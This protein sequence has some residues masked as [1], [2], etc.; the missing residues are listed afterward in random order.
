MALN[1]KSGT[2]MDAADD[3]LRT[4]ERFQASLSRSTLP[5]HSMAIDFPQ[6]SPLGA[7]ALK[8]T[9]QK[10]SRTLGVMCEPEDMLD[11]MTDVADATAT[12]LQDIGLI[13]VN[14]VMHDVPAEHRS[15]LLGEIIEACPYAT[16]MI[17]DYTMLDMTDEQAERLFTAKLEHERI[18]EKSRDVYLDEHLQFTYDSLCGLMMGRLTSVRGHRL[19][20]G[21]AL[22]AGSH[23][24]LLWTPESSEDWADESIWATSG[25]P[26][27]PLRRRRE[28]LVEGIGITT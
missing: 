19:P 5:Q 22:V 8:L 26:S 20:A 15:R 4:I 2:S 16:V 10:G 11:R 21:R 24:D 27:I 6:R 9:A 28:Q 13:L 3:M 23:S 1:S 12:R 14:Y 25:L 18:R 7:R 17:A